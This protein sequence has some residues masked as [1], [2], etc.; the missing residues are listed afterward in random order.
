ML[1]SDIREQQ[2][3]IFIFRVLYLDELYAAPIV[4]MKS[5]QTKSPWWFSA[6][7]HNRTHIVHH[8][9]KGRESSDEEE[10]AAPLNLKSDLLWLN[11]LIEILQLPQRVTTDQTPFVFSTMLLLLLISNKSLLSTSFVLHKCKAP[12]VKYTVPWSDL[13]LG[14]VT[15]GWQC[16]VWNYLANHSLP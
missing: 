1:W 14:R 6:N 13:F 9:K 16:L 10:E 4:E 5:P 2:Q 15:D 8:W 11:D 7:V 12:A 3:D